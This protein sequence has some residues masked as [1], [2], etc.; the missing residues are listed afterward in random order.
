MPQSNVHFGFELPHFACL[1]A[2]K[3]KKKTKQKQKRVEEI[4]QSNFERKIFIQSFK[5]RGKILKLKIK[6]KNIQ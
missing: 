5:S 3:D 2:R 6:I 4:C 1:L